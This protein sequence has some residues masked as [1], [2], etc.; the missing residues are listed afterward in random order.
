MIKSPYSLNK[1]IYLSSDKSIFF[2]KK[3]FYIR[4]VEELIAK[5]YKKQIFKTPTHLSIGQEAIPVGIINNLSKYDKI[6]CSHRAHAHYL[7]SNGSLY[8]LF[9]ELMGKR[10]GCSG[11]KG[12]SVHLTSKKNGFMGSLPILG[13]SIGLAVGAAL[14]LKI[15][16][17]KNIAVCFFGD[18]VLEEGIFYET[19]NFAIIKNL[20]VLFVL[21][22]NFFASEMSI[23]ERLGKFS[24]Y[25]KKLSGFNINYEK[26]DGNNID[27]VHNKSKKAINLIKKKITPIFLECVTYRILEH[28]G[29]NY[30]NLENKNKR[31]E[32]EVL[33]WKKA[34]PLLNLKNY[35]INIKKI[36]LNFIEKIENKIIKKINLDYNRA[37][38]SKFPNK[39]ELYSHVY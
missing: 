3:L 6:Y 18:A 17:T 4:T 29:P 24:N 33:H 21:E 39:K 14:S 13:E 28:C 23:G 8:K 32:S 9:C 38:Q 37:L 36:Q 5:E 15:K 25:Q 11:G 2:Y 10:D 22:N 30:D 1:K 26:I 7:S 19:L 12:G 34:C 20:P 27:E 16:K 35:L 31:S